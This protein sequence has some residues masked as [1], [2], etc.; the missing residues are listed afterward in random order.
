MIPL[1]EVEP[2]DHARIE[3]AKLRKVDMV[4]DLVMTVQA[5]ARGSMVETRVS[6]P[7]I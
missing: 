2:L 3:H 5:S 6:S 7:G 1:E 4:F